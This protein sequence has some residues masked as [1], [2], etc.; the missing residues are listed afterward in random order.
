MSNH[1]LGLVLVVIV[2][3]ALTERAAY[4][5]SDADIDQLTSYA[6]ILGRATACGEDTENAARRVGAWV[7]RTFNGQERSHMMMILVLGMQHH[8]EQQAKGNSPD[9]CSSISRTLTKMVWP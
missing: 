3:I 8:A 7:D 6:V 4:A 2:C 1:L 9:S 5:A